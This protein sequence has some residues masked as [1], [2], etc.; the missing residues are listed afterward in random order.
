MPQRQQ[1]VGAGSQCDQQ[2]DREKTQDPHGY[3][4]PVGKVAAADGMRNK[5]NQATSPHGDK[6]VQPP[7]VS[8]SASSPTPA[9]S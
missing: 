3:P 2:R 6:A 9:Q 8:S 4:L 5:G 1:V 7:E